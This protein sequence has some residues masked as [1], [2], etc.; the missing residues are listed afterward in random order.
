MARIQ[1]WG[2]TNL[3]PTEVVSVLY[4]KDEFGPVSESSMSSPSGEVPEVDEVSLESD[5][6]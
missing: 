1:E 3:R 4:S 2:R 6:M 5:K